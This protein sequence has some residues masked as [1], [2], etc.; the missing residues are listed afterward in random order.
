[1]P[2]IGNES[3]PI[4]SVTGVRSSGGEGSGPSLPVRASQKAAGSGPSSPATQAVTLPDLKKVLEGL[5][6]HENVGLAYVIDRETHS[7]TIKVIDRDTNEIIRQIPSEE[8]TKLR[9][10]MRDLF[11]LL[12][13]AEV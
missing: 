10:V 1:M 4:E 2:D 3:K 11:G 6:P 7:V 5:V 9:A 13:K 8:M 12:F